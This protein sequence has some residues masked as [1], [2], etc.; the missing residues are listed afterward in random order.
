MGSQVRSRG[1]LAGVLCLVAVGAARRAG[2]EP[3]KVGL[4]YRVPAGCPGWGEF[5]ALLRQA[6]GGGWRFE[7]DGGSRFLVDVREEGD[8]KVGRLRRAASTGARE[9]R[10][11]DCREI[12][13]ALALTT[14]LS[15]ETPRLEIAPVTAP[16]ISP[17][18]R[19]WSATAGV[20][21]VALLPPAPMLEARITLQATTGGLDLRLAVAHA[22][23]DLLARGAAGFSLS[24]VAAGVCPLRW[25][26]LRLCL[27]AETGVLAAAGRQVERPR[28]SRLWWLAGGGTVSAAKTFSSSLSGELFVGVRRPLR[29]TDF[30]FESPRHDV[31]TVPSAVVA[32]GVALVRTIP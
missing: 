27:D 5:T 3:A 31:G 6:T 15:L 21:A 23:N 20:A 12:V 8:R 26:A 1:R 19:G 7:E 18:D 10:G 13:Q 4:S 2:A 25:R 17:Y 11:T 32:G 14:A 24:V 28:T 9:V 29:R 22:R 30:V 16:V